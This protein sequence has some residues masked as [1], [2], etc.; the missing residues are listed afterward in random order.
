M[1]NYPTTTNAKDLNLFLGLIGYYRRFIKDFNKKTKPLTNLLKQN[2]QFIW[3][4]LCQES[5][6]YFKMF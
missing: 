2:Q 4:D 5:F 3:S 1:V 6:N